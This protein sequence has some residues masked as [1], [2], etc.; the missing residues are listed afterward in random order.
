[1]T[2]TQTD[3]EGAI[4]GWRQNVISMNA[5]FIT[6]VCFMYTFI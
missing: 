2:Y 3:Y 4:S 6:E 5:L 1:M